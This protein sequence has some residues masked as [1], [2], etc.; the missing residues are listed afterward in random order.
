METVPLLAFIPLA[1]SPMKNE[2]NGSEEVEEFFP[3]SKNFQLVKTNL[4]IFHD[5]RRGGNGMERK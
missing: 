4:Y 2:K 5:K 3:L 1:N